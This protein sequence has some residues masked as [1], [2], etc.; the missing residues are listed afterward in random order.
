MKAGKDGVHCDSTS[1][2]QKEWLNDS[3]RRKKMLYEDALHIYNLMKNDFIKTEFLKKKK[4]YKYCC[5][6]AKRKFYRKK[7]AELENLKK[8][9]AD[10]FS[11]TV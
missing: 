1:Y 9:K 7:A 5:R 8:D 3:C 6:N 4:D 2:A 10:R 11:E